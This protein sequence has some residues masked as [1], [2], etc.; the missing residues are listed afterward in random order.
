M[1]VKFSYRDFDGSVKESEADVH[2]EN[3]EF[4][5]VNLATFGYGKRASASMHWKPIP[6]AIGLLIGGREVVSY[7]ITEAA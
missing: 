5:A 4:W 1:K 2:E 7:T 3:G 6:A